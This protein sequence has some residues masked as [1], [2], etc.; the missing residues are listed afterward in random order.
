MDKSLVASLGVATRAI[1]G[2]HHIHSLS[3]LNMGDLPRTEE[4]RRTVLVV[5]CVDVMCFP[6]YVRLPPAMERH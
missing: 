5:D 6:L 2:S 1:L 3:A 4:Y